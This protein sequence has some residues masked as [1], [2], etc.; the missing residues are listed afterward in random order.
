MVVMAFAIED[1]ARR[2][3]PVRTED[4][5]FGAFRDQPLREGTL[6]CLRFMTDIESH[7]VCYLRDLLV[8]PSHQ[9]P[10]VTTFLTMWNYEEH[11]HGEAL[12]EVLAAHG[13]PAGLT[14]V[15]AIRAGLG[16]KD[17]LAPLRQ[18]VLA[19]V[20]GPDFVAVHMTWG[21][22]NEWA[23]YAGYQR[24]I[25]REPHPVLTELLRRIMRQ[26]TRHVA[27]YVTQARRRLAASARA[28][29][30]TRFALRRF[31]APVGSSVMPERETRHLLN[32]LFDGPG[33]ARTVRKIDADVERLPGMA[34]LNLV[35]RGIARYGIIIE[36]SPA[37]AAV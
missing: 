13:E 17:R 10:E 12:G 9:D 14:R 23:T 6:R 30:L 33:G 31:W 19:N 25:E 2:A 34:G 27:F 32:Y 21:A 18:S 5:D 26:E 28:R 3:A 8:T 22:V 16:W 37:Q 11:W 20:I 29:R 1:Y 4:L 35:R 36:P 24:L 7:T 15:E